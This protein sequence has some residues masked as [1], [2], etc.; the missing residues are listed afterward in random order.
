MGQ[1]RH[2]YTYDELDP[3]LKSGSCLWLPK[4]LSA[5]CQSG[6]C[7]SSYPG[8]AAVFLSPVCYPPYISILVYGPFSLLQ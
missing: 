7:P 1:G 8:A 6:G 3:R 5:H 4:T 2:Y